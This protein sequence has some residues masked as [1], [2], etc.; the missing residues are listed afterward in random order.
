MTSS[1]WDGNLSV[2]AKTE[3]PVYMAIGENDSYY[4]SSYLKNA[5]Q[6]LHEFYEEQGLAVQKIKIGTYFTFQNIDFFSP[7]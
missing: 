2:L 3:T 5:Y 6:E 4:G 7:A 1:K